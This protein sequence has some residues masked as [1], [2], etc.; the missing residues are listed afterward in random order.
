MFNKTKLI[1]LMEE[2]GLSLAD[3]AKL[4]GVPYSTLRDLYTGKNKNPLANTLKKI[5]KGL[6]IDS[7]Y[8]VDDD[9]DDLRSETLND[10][11]KTNTTI[12]KL[13]ET[14]LIKDDNI[15]DNISQ[16]LLSTLKDEIKQKLKR[17]E[18]KQKWK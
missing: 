9:M 10:L 11:E 5:A 3:V 2:N 8:F 15:D 16:F 6:N 12:D 4:C 18:Q 14:G 7:D 17:K 13:I 1:K